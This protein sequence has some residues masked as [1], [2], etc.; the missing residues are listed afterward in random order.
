MTITRKREREEREAP[1]QMIKINFPRESYAS[2][3]LEFTVLHHYMYSHMRMLASLGS[4]SF[5]AKPV[6]FLG[7]LRPQKSLENPLRHLW[8][9]KDP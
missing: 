3:M 7:S 1:T 4:W 9:L 6:L 8:K 5:L 2:G